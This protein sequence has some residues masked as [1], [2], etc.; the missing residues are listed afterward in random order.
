MRH[1]D[2]MFLSKDPTFG[3]FTRVSERRCP[4]CRFRMATNNYGKFRC[5]RCG[6]ADEQDVSKLRARGLGYRSTSPERPSIFGRYNVE[7]K[8]G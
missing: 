6:F 8:T 2:D 7:T 5:N 1:Y 4:K 3:W